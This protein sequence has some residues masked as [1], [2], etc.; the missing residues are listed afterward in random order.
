MKYK[1]VYYW[2]KRQ[3]QQASK[4]GFVTTMF[5]RK[6]NLVGLDSDNQRIKASAERQAL[7]TTIQGTAADIIKIA[8]IKVDK[9][10]KFLNPKCKLILQIH[11]ELVYE[12]PENCATDIAEAI[13]REMEN[14]VKL[15]VPLVADVA[16]GK[17]LGE[18]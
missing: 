7:N 11:D 1:G 2:M 8:M 9:M 16:T 13:K 15:K 17:N 10:L 6:R 12:C 14:A 18:L 4:D 3:K 5:G